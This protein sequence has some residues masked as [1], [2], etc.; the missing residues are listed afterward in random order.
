MKKSLLCL[1]LLFIG[2]VTAHSE[3]I[4]D[5][6]TSQVF[7]W[8]TSNDHWNII[9][10]NGCMKIEPT[11]SQNIGM[12]LL[13]GGN[14]ARD[15]WSSPAAILTTFPGP[16]PSSFKFGVKF[17]FRKYDKGTSETGL[18]FNYTDEDNYSMISLYGNSLVYAVRSEGKTKTLS[19]KKVKWPKIKKDQELN[20][21]LEYNDHV[22][23]FY[24]NNFPEFKVKNI[25]IESPEIGIYV[26]RHQKLTVN[27]V[28]LESM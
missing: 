26:N 9:H 25:T 1:I 17:S 7:E 20:R 3:V 10:E 21:E 18:V 19:K 22:L 6:F 27:E 5:D 13:V 24:N 15:R 23:T 12:K 16:I 2:W 8:S 28:S 14:A 4:T 11:T